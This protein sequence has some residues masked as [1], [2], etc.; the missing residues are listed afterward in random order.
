MTRARD[1]ANIFSGG[2]IPSASLDSDGSIDKSVVTVP[3][4]SNADG[5]VITSSSG[6]IDGA[7]YSIIEDNNTYSYDGGTI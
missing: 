3:S 7:M 4:G 5:G 6:V 1:M 2:V